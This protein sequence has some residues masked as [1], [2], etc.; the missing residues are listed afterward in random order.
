[1]SSPL[2]VDGLYSVPSWIGPTLDGLGSPE[3]VAFVVLV[4]L[5]SMGASAQG[6]ALMALAQEKS[7]VGSE[8]T[9]LGLPRAIGDGTYIVAP[10]IM[11]YFCDIMGDAI[12]GIACTIAGGAIVLG[13]IALLSF[14]Q[15]DDD[16]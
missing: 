11:G 4:L 12:P 15:S 16:A 5:W 1:M 8:A 14:D 6:P 2:V 9:A 13:S 3:A 10:L 7:P